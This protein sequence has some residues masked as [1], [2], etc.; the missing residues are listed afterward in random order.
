MILLNFIVFFC[1]NWFQFCPRML[2]MKEV[3][4]LFA[5]N[6]DFLITISLE[7]NVADRRYLKLWILLAQVIWVSNIKGLQHRVLKILWFK[8]WILF[9]RLNSFVQE[10]YK[11]RKHLTV[12]NI[13]LDL[14]CSVPLVRKCLWQG[15]WRKGCLSE[16][17]RLMYSYIHHQHPFRNYKN[18]MCNCN[19]P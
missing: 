19:I 16:I 2:D 12:Y 5:T 14:S 18:S 11:W 9:Q 3:S 4:Y 6:S 15:N 1:Y 7:P 17:W 10:C 8:Y 13:C